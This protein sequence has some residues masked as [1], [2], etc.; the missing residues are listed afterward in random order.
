MIDLPHILTLSE[1]AD[2]LGVDTHVVARWAHDELLQVCA[3]S[4]SGELLFY[5]W[6]VE[7]DGPKLAANEHVRIVKGRNK[8]RV[9][10]HD[11]HQLACGC[12]LAGDDGDRWPAWLCPAA[13]MLQFTQQ[14]TAVMAAAFPDDPVLAGITRAAVA[15]L[16]NHLT[17]ANTSPADRPKQVQQEA[18][19][20]CDA[21]GVA[22]RRRKDARPS[23]G[24]DAA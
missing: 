15:A 11:G 2:F 24:Q 7:R 23:A 1:V 4:E 5:R 6:R 22:G 19:A 12:V 9:I 18:L 13:R 10:L 21:P 14:L 8:R 17:P 16:A 20:K 3:R